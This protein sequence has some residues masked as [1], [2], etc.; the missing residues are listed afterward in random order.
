M[1]CTFLQS[2]HTQTYDPKSKLAA[3]FE[4]RRAS[5]LCLLASLSGLNAN[6]ELAMDCSAFERRWNFATTADLTLQYSSCDELPQELMH[7]YGCF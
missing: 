3:R 1:D 7:F 5:F 6:N 2:L 4:L